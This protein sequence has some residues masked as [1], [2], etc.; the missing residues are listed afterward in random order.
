VSYYTPDVTSLIFGA[1]LAID[2]SLFV[3]LQF[4]EEMKKKTSN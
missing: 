2:F 1:G 3:H 4:T